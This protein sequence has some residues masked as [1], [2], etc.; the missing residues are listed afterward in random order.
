M[1]PIDGKEAKRLLGDIIAID[2]V[3]PSLVPGGAGE[4]A[5]AAYIVDGVLPAGSDDSEAAREAQEAIGGP[6]AA[7]HGLMLNGHIDTVGGPST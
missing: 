5:V 1:W 2:S 6:L 7:R 4:R 3:N